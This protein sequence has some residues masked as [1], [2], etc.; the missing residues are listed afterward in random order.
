MRSLIQSLRD[1]WS[2][3]K[4][5][6][7]FN[8]LKARIGG[9][10]SIDAMGVRDHTYR[11]V[12]M[13]EFN[14]EICQ[15]GK[16]VDYEGVCRVGRE[17]DKLRLRMVPQE[18]PDELTGLTHSALVL[19]LHYECGHQDAV[20]SGL[21]RTVKGRGNTGQFEIEW[22]GT[23]TVYFRIGDLKTCYI[24]KISILKD[25]D[26]NGIVNSDEIRSEAV[27]YYD[28]H[29][30]LQD[31]AGQPYLEYLFVER[32]QKTGWWQIW[33]GSEVDPCRILVS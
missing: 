29:T 32:N 17:I 15:L 22:G 23:K 6:G 10:L 14:R 1:R 31:E 30:E 13:S 27:E 5:L 3:P 2:K 18:H 12:S 25:E 19:R 28:Y 4:E 33:K 8:P 11:I 7:I 26:G 9:S 20:E 21:E 16:F 24:A